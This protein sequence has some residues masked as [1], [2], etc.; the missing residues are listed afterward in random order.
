MERL[1]RSADALLLE[2]AFGSAAEQYEQAL[3][4]AD[5]LRL[6]TGAAL[7]RLLNEGAL[8]LEQGHGEEAECHFSVAL[9]IAPQNPVALKNLKRFQNMEAVQQL[10]A[11]GAVHEKNKSLSLAHTDYQEALRLDPDS[12][13]ARAA[14]QRVEEQVAAK[15]FQQQMSAGFTKLYEKEYDQARKMFLKARAIRPDSGEVGDALAQVDAAIL[16]DRIETLQRKALALESVEKWQQAHE[17]YQ[18]V[19]KLDAV[20]QFALQGSERTAKMVRLEKRM[21]YYL[22]NQ[23]ALESDAYLEKALQL[24]TEAQSVKSMGP[25]LQEKLQKLNQ[26]LT[27]AQTPVAVIIN[28]DNLTEVSI[29]RVGKL[30][31]FARREMQL[32]P[33]TYTVVGERDGFKDVRQQVMVKAGQGPVRITVKCADKI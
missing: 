25:R 24:I 26:L 17:T 31:G 16:I 11:S 20:I 8:A 3:E 12:K 23:D 10:M 21:T 18:A 33:G 7:Q 5:V 27:A 19:L 2:K 1:G 29:Y 6:Q 9:K 15:E 22:K 30:G 14:F 32:R 28:S 13:K 4:A